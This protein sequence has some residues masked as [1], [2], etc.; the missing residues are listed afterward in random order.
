MNTKKD[1]AIKEFYSTSNCA[2]AV[3]TSF[4]QELQVDESVLT[5]IA[6]GFGAGM[7]RL[8]K[9]CG[10]VTGGM[11]VIGL[12]KEGELD[13]DEI[14]KL[15][16]KFES[17]FKAIHKVADCSALLGCDLNTDEGQIHFHEHDLKDSV[18]SNCVK[19]SIDI[20]EHLL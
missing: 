14:Y 6:S 1:K 12:K 3:L 5:K 13:K 4:A 2:Q 19:N 18:C 20:L 7:G 11:M 15:V 9:T 16:N 17:N 10:A 8:Q